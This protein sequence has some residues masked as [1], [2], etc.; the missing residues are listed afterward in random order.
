MLIA[1]LFALGIANFALNRAV[2][3]SG[4]PLLQS[5]PM[6]AHRLGAR[7]SLATEFIILVAAMLLASQGWG[8]M[9]WAYAGYT[10]LNAFSTWMIVNGKI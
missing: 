9:G 8:V 5:L 10:A 7:L 3:E 4:H 6:H 2:L 1:L